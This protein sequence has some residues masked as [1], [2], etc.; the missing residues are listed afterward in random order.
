MSALDEELSGPRSKHRQRT[1]HCVDSP[2]SRL[3]FE[4]V[5]T[6]HR[7]VDTPAAVCGVPC[8]LVKP[9][10]VRNSPKLVSKS[11]RFLKATRA[12]AGP[13]PLKVKRKAVKPYTVRAPLDARLTPG[14][15]ES[16]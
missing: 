6:V 13:T 16:P 11:N 7:R 8:L 5:L 2:D 1:R 9:Y 15:K 12:T 4:F 10:L 3:M 14:Q